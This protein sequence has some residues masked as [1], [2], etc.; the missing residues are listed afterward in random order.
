MPSIGGIIEGF[1]QGKSNLENLTGEEYK[2]LHEVYAMAFFSNCEGKS[3]LDVL[4]PNIPD[5]SIVFNDLAGDAYVDLALSKESILKDEEK[6]ILTINSKKFLPSN[7]GSKMDASI[8]FTKEIFFEAP[9]RARW[10]ILKSLLRDTT[11]SQRLDILKSNAFEEHKRTPAYESLMKKLN[12]KH[13]T[14]GGEDDR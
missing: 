12:V 8:E 4:R 1:L 5:F 6:Y 3:G 11:P 13:E 7:L 9:S 10:A 2:L 14:E